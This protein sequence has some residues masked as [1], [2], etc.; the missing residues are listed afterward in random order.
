MSKFNLRDISERLTHSRNTSS[1]VYEFL[2]ALEEFRGDW[3]ASLAFYDVG[4]DALV[5][6]YERDG[7]RLVRREIVVPADRLPP[8]LV[9]SLFQGSAFFN[10][11]EQNASLTR[12]FGPGQAY[13]ADALEASDLLPLTVLSEW[14]SCVCVPLGDQGDLLGI[15]VIVSQKKNAFAGRV[16]SEIVPVKSIATI[17]LA[18]Q[19]GR[20]TRGSE[21][22]AVA[23]GGG[24][25][26]DGDGDGSGESQ[27]YLRML[28][29]HTAQLEQEN[30]SKS[31]TLEALATEIEQLDKSSSTYQQ[32]L[33]R[34]KSAVS[35]LEE[36]TTAATE[37]LAHGFSEFNMT[38]WEVQELECTLEFMKD[39]FVALQEAYEPAELPQAMME[40]LC[41]RFG[42]ERCSLMIPDAPGESLRVAAHCGL[43]STIV[44]RVRVRFGQGI[45][46]WVAHNRKALI[47]RMR[48]EIQGMPPAEQSGYNSDSFVAVPL[49]HNDVLYGVLSLSNKLGGEA[50]TSTDLDRALL[51]ASVLAIHLSTLD[52]ARRAAAWA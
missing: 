45:A 2:R 24:D 31:A 36:Q 48:E 22:V 50:F 41:E 30:R 32:E 42:V 15:L 16:L 9:R 21:P 4:Q 5:N 3:R 1:V 35:A 44:D 39:V 8:R 29:Q 51:A 33:E 12:G 6:V 18:Q 25:D 13:V 20:E 47:V 38:Q 28:N 23:T 49:V 7:K 26:G 40:W 46:G 17:A 10:H 27:E 14:Q 11:G 34:V 52:Q 37:H 19:L 43:D